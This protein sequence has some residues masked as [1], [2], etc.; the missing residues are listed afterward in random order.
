[1][2]CA[3]AACSAERRARSPAHSPALSFALSAARSWALSPACTW[4]F[5]AAEAAEEGREQHAPRCRL[6]LGIAAGLADGLCSGF[7]AGFVTG[8]AVGAA[9]KRGARVARPRAA[10]ARAACER[11]SVAVMRSA[12][13]SW[14]GGLAPPFP[15]SR[16]D[17][18]ACICRACICC[19]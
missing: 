2:C 7:A 13:S 19:A 15:P 10:C 6:L 16:L 1:M 5:D 9:T 18:C 14:L 12:A 8:A 4:T 11:R 17:G 3:A